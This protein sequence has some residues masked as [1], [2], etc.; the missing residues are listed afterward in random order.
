MKPWERKLFEWGLLGY[1]VQDVIGAHQEES[2]GIRQNHRMYLKDWHALVRRHFVAHE[3][4]L[5]VPER[6]WGERWVKQLA[7]QLDRYKS[8]WRAAR[9]LG[10]TM[11]A[12]CRKAG[13]AKPFDFDAT[14]FEDLLR[15]PDCHGSMRR[16]DDDLLQC[17]G[18][19]YSAANEGKVYNLLPSAD[20]RELY[21][22]DR[23]DVIDFSLPGHERHLLEGWHDLEGSYGNKYR[24]IGGRATAVLKRVSAGPLQLRVRGFA[25]E[26]QFHAE[27]PHIELRANGA[28][29]GQWSID[30]VGL[31]VL[32]ADVPESDEYTIEILSSPEWSAPGD[33]R[34]FTVNLSM[35]RL[36]PQEPA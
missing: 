34:V 5:F 11:A 1:F 13:D 24:W 6:G 2:F 17:T 20:R 28:R 9:L 16:T 14:R 26:T 35:L 27:R 33:G 10:G 15:C 31:F 3:F 18:C 29:I 4:D 30:R 8:V 23:E 19:G 32:E 7:V 22:G 36:V 12:F 25:Q 21:P